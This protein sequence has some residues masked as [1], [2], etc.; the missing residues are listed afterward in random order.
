MRSDQRRMNLLFAATVLLLLSGTAFIYLQ[1]QASTQK[2]MHAVKTVVLN[3]AEAIA[4]RARELLEEPIRSGNITAD[5]AIRARCNRML[6][7]FNVN[8]VKYV[9][10]LR[11]EA[12]A[13]WVYVLDGTMD[14]LQRAMFTQPFRPVQ[15]RLWQKAEQCSGPLY[16]YQNSV[17]GVWLTY[18]APL[19]SYEGKAYVLVLD[20]SAEDI[21]ELSNVVRPVQT[22]MEYY[23]LLLLLV[24]FIV[25]VLMWYWNTQRKKSYIDP[26]THIYNRAYLRQVEEQLHLQ[27]YTLAIFDLDHFKYIND[28]FGHD[29]GDKVLQ[30]VGKRLMSLM[31][32][33]DIAIR[34]GGEEFLLLIRSNGDENVAKEVSNRVFASMSNE[35][36]RVSDTLILDITVSMGVVIKSDEHASL[37]AAIKRADEMLYEAKHAGRNRMLFYGESFSA[38]RMLSYPEAA[39]AVMNGEVVAYFQPIFNIAEETVSRYELL[40]RMRDTD[41]TLYAPVSFLSTLRGTNTYRLFS[42]QILLNAFKTIREFDIDVSVNFNVNDFYDTALY[43]MVEELLQTHSPYVNRL[44]L[45][46]LEESEVLDLGALKS[47]FSAFRAQGVKIAIDDFGS[48][49][50]NYNYII[51]LKP[52]ILKI[53]SSLIRDIEHAKDRQSVVESIVGICNT[54]NIVTIAEF[55]ETEAAAIVLKSLGVD[56]LQGYHIGKPSPVVSC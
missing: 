20:I 15:S 21:A 5:A 10:V 38:Q 27:H 26:L 42:K 4:L 48:G 13:H 47:R 54:L 24:L 17:E 52:D 32:L 9:Y 2:S 49:F 53:D 55:V 18:I 40:A 12:E 43:D 44:T 6:S 50:S 37:S 35:A 31:R 29:V 41:G 56:M 46:L 33:D 19:V 14:P 1:F 8:E 51:E 23:M 16:E 30:H 39:E 3:D 7:A 22:S 34:Y 36:I 11:R 45:E 25:P 28:R